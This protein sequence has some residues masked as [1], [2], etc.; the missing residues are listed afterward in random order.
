MLVFD[1]ETGAVLDPDEGELR[2]GLRLE[3]IER[4]FRSL[5]AGPVVL[6]LRDPDAPGVPGDIAGLIEQALQ[7][8]RGGLGGNPILDLLTGLGPEAFAGRPH[9]RGRRSLG[10]LRRERPLPPR[11]RPS[12]TPPFPPW[13]TRTGTGGLAGM[14]VAADDPYANPTRVVTPSDPEGWERVYEGSFVEA[15]LVTQLSG[16]FPS[17]VLAQ[18]A[19]PFYSG[20]RQRIL[21]PRGS[22]FVGTAQQVRGRDQERLAVAFHRLVFPGGS[23]LPLHFQGL[24]QIGGGRPQGPGGPPLPQ[25]LPGSGER[26]DPEWPHSRGRQSLYRHHHR[27]RDR[28]RR[29]GARPGRRAGHGTLPQPTPHDHHSRRPPA[30]YL[31]HQRCPSP[32]SWRS[33]SSA[34]L[35]THGSHA[36]RPFVLRVL[37]AT[38]L[39]P[40][41][42]TPV[43]AQFTDPAGL[44][45]RIVNDRQPDH[46]DRPPD[47][48]ARGGSR[49]GEQPG[50]HA[51]ADARRSARGGRGAGRCHSTQ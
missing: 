32:A 18:V 47:L 3:E 23:Y 5:R 50:G 33:A 8:Q 21:I 35:R 19:V 51:D 30:A 43:H 25:H 28:E 9:R 1:P 20:D 34:V 37:L 16:D 17:P 6:S 41:P 13:A 36:M 40:V 38:A 48:D 7:D 24:D 15:V 10:A 39:L 27:G 44:T 14:A 29:A 42:A 31:V 11:A 49:P 22:R 26:R 45:Q 4:R 12:W 46:P 2:R